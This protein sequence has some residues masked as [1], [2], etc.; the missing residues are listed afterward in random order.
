M[1]NRA[2]KR[3]SLLSNLRMIDFSSSTVYVFDRLVTL[4][5]ESAYSPSS[6]LCPAEMSSSSQE[7]KPRSSSIGPFNNVWGSTDFRASI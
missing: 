5:I 2:M 3:T 6:S 4:D 7:A 1:Y